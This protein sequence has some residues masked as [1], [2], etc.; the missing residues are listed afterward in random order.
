MGKSLGDVL[1]KASGGAQFGHDMGN[2]AEC[3]CREIIHG[4]FRVVGGF[5]VKAYPNP[6]PPVM[7][8]VHDLGISSVQ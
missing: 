4:S 8:D 5:H 1:A 6:G 2:G 3:K 7:P